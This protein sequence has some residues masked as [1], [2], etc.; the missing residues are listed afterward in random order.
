MKWVFT[1]TVFL[2]L[3][4]VTLPFNFVEKLNNIT[5]LHLRGDYFFHILM[6]LPWMFFQK[7]L[8]VK[9]LPW[10]LLGVVFASATEGLQYFI[11]WRSF[12]INDILANVSGV[13]I[14]FLLFII[15]E[16]A[17]KANNP[18]KGET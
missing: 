18:Q 13:L 15:Y 8:S 7:T 1:T 6:F 16:Q 9:R 2:I 11:P 4:L 12:N 17:T 10:L 5:I 14:G 3:L